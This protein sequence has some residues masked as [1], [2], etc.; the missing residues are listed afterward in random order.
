VCGGAAE[1]PKQLGFPSLGIF[2]VRFR[3]FPDQHALHKS[4]NSSSAVLNVG[5]VE[6]TVQLRLGAQTA[7]RRYALEQEIM[8]NVFWADIER[9]G[10][11]LFTIADCDD[12]IVAFELD[13]NEWEDEKA[14]SKKWYSVATVALQLPAL[15]TKGEVYDIDDLRLTL[16][17]D[18][19]TPIVSVPA[20]E[21]E[22]VSIDEN[23]DIT[24]VVSP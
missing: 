17:H 18:L 11:V 1:A 9:P 3:Y 14:F 19:T 2:A 13:E 6:G 5:R 16:T 23:G 20:S 24:P 8:E 12:A 22:T 21:K 15:V 10:I 4:L 7:Q